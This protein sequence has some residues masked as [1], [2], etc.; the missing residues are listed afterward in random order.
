MPRSVVMALASEPQQILWCT[1]LAAL[2]IPVTGLPLSAHLETAIAQAMRGAQPPLLLIDIVALAQL[3]TDAEEFGPWQRKHCA[4]IDLLLYCSSLRTVNAQAR[5]WA[6]S[7][8]ARDLLP[9]FALAHAGESLGPAIAHLLSVPGM[10]TPD[11]TTLKNALQKLPVMRDDAAPLD[12]AWRHHHALCQ[13]GIDPD[14]LIAKMRGNDGVDIRARRFRTKTYTE[15]FIGNAAV[16]WLAQSGATRDR[17]EALH[18]GQALLELGY[19]DHVAHEQPFQDEH[20]FYRMRADTP[21]LNAIDLCAVTGGLRNGAVAIRD[22]KFHGVRYPACFVGAE[23][24]AWMREQFQLSETEAVALGQR[25]M[26][27]YIVYHVADRQP[28]R[29]G[30]FFYRFFSTANRPRLQTGISA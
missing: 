5:S 13:R 7:L 27:L 22:R 9:G 1:A 15:C 12:Q 25:L 17:T 24:V 29:A 16:D 19:I 14:R 26:D 20:F 3:G 28:F 23:A 30:R 18:I 21:R 8:G 6:Q 11:E 4:G 10:G 2:G